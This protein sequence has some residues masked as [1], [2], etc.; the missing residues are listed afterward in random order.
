MPSAGQSDVVQEEIVTANYWQN[1]AGASV[2][3]NIRSSKA[4]KHVVSVYE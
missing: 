4:C 3:R 2:L 1:N